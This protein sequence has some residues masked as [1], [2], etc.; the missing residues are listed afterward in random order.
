MENW[1]VEWEAEEQTLAEEKIQ[2]NIIQGD[3]LSLL[4][5]VLAMMPLSY[6]V[7]KCTDV[8]KLTKSPERFNHL[9]DDIKLFF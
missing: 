6:I 3:S 9:I 5:F 1:N 7:R 8:Y 2:R 4:L